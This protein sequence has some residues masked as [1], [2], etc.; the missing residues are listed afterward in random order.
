MEAVLREYEY[1]SERLFSYENVRV[2]FFPTRNGSYAI[3]TDM[4]ITA[5]TTRISIAIW[6]NVCGLGMR[7]TEENLQEELEEMRRIVEEYDFEEL[8][9]GEFSSVGKYFELI[10]QFEVLFTPENAQKAGIL[11]I[12]CESR[13]AAFF[14]LMVYAAEMGFL[15]VVSGRR[16]G[17]CL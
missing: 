12:D 9:S 7:V 10:K 13:P 1:I 11:R 14:L 3:C 16:C 2:F 4:R 6:R 15:L 8:F 5:I 17:R